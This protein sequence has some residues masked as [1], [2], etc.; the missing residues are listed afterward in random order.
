MLLK[1]QMPTIEI[2]GFLKQ[3][4]GKNEMVAFMWPV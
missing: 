3:K 4:I 2:N 1:V